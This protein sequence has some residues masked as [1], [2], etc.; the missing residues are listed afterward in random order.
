MDEE[1]ARL[2]CSVGNTP[3]GGRGDV[4]VAVQY[5]ALL[6]QGGG[7]PLWKA[8]EHGDAHA[9]I[10]TKDAFPA[11]P[12]YDSSATWG[13]SRARIPLPSRRGTGGRD[14]IRETQQDRHER[15][16]REDVR[17]RGVWIHGRLDECFQEGSRQRETPHRAGR[18]MHVEGMLQQ[19]RQT[20]PRD[21]AHCTPVREARGSGSRDTHAGSPAAGRPGHEGSRG[22]REEHQ[23]DSQTSMQTAPRTDNRARGSTD[24]DAHRHLDRHTRRHTIGTPRTYCGSGGASHGSYRDAMPS[25]SMLTLN[26]NGISMGNA[27]GKLLHEADS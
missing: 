19:R 2:A 17:M 7:L 20:V 6:L 22:R 9:A 1:L 26:V 25:F 14:R 13:E 10:D 18:R 24:S 4:T 12:G 15:G 21:T 3:C 23:Q 5:G 27:F 11:R 16:E 8:R